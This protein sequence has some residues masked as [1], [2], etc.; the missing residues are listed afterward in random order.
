MGLL[1]MVPMKIPGARFNLPYLVTSAFLDQ[2][3]TAQKSEAVTRIVIPCS[4]AEID[5]F[6]LLPAQVDMAAEKPVSA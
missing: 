6:N 2:L 5:Q 1:G 4:S 3:A